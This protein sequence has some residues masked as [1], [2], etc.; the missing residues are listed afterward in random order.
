M[1]SQKPHPAATY[2]RFADW[3]LHFGSLSKEAKHTVNVVIKTALRK[4]D[5][6]G[7]EQ[8]LSNLTELN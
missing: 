3:R 1:S 2:I 7:A 4:Y 6:Y 8:I 5:H